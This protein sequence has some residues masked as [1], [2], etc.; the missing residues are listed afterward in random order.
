MRNQGE[1]IGQNIVSGGNLREQ[2]ATAER[3]QRRLGKPKVQEMSSA[4]E[5]RNATAREKV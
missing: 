5:N 2:R 1:N 4:S 3:S